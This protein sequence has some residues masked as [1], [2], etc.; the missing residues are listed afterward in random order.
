MDLLLQ[1]ADP[2][3][4]EQL[5][6]RK[7]LLQVLQENDEEV[8]KLMGEA[9]A[10]AAER[11]KSPGVDDTVND[12]AVVQMLTSHYTMTAWL[13][14]P[15]HESLMKEHPRSSCWTVTVGMA[16]AV[17]QCLIV[18]ALIGDLIDRDRWGNQADDILGAT[19][20]AG[21]GG[22]IGREMPYCRS[23]EAWEGFVEGGLGSNSTESTTRCW[24]QSYCDELGS[25]ATVLE[26]SLVD[27]AN[28]R[29]GFLNSCWEP[30]SESSGKGMSKMEVA[31]NV[32]LAFFLGFEIYSEQ[33]QLFLQTLLFHSIPRLKV[34]G[35]E[36]GEGKPLTIATTKGAAASGMYILRTLLYTVFIGFRLYFL[37]L[38]SLASAVLIIADSGIT[39]ACLNGMA[40]LFI[41]DLDERLYKVGKWGFHSAADT[42][43][44]KFRNDYMERFKEAKHIQPLLHVQ[45]SGT[46]AY[47]ALATPFTF[48]VALWCRNTGGL[49]NLNPVLKSHS[50]FSTDSVVKM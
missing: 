11:E 26:L 12:D 24:P 29:H 2:K 35:V 13:L 47:A 34:N 43:G 1:Q 10:A 36:G 25:N 33:Q 48:A 27:A 3:G 8:C 37:G 42:E 4:D 38:V 19:A 45:E 39:D 14:T 17:L 32:L 30:A 18:H 49:W 40:L 22:I 44:G 6:F 46:L 5:K 23:K 16:A 7:L 21:Q 15:T 28:T 9:V 50:A 31:T 20:G 41:V